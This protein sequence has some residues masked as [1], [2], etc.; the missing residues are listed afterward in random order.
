M[1][2][3]CHD[4]HPVTE[5]S[6]EKA[7]IFKLYRAL[8]VDPRAAPLEH[9]ASSSIMSDAAPSPITNPSRQSINGRHE[10]V[11]SPFHWLIV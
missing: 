8:S 6:C 2:P 4:S 3:G 7:S 10:T 9:V 5:T 11:G 1:A